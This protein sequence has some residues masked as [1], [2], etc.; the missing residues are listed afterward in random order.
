MTEQVFTMVNPAEMQVV[1]ALTQQLLAKSSDGAC[2][3]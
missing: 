2:I 1:L 3:S